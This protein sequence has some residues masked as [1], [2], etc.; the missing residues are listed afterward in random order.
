[1]DFQENFKETENWHETTTWI[2]G[3][4]VAIPAADD[5]DN[6]QD[7]VLALTLLALAQNETR[8]LVVGERANGNWNMFFNECRVVIVEQNEMMIW[9][10][11]EIPMINYFVDR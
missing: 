7:D 11:L 2:V 3:D 4:T 1:M 10:W 5:D 9:G 8:V 6:Y